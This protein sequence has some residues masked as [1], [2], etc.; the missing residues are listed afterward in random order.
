MSLTS[1]N[2]SKKRAAAVAAVALSSAL[3]LS[4]CSD[5]GEDKNGAS[6]S[7]EATQSAGSDGADGSTKAADDK[8]L[9]FKDSYVTAKPADKNMTSVFGTLHNTTDK[10]ITITEVKGDIDGAKYELH[11]VNRDGEMQQIS[12]LTI[13]AGEDSVLEPGGNHIMI[14]EVSDEIAA[15]DSLAFTLVDKDGK[16]YKLDNVPVRVQQSTH[17]HYG[18]AKDGEMGN[19]D[20]MQHGGDHMQHGGEHGHEH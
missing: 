9:E 6:T 16:E 11:E 7:A 17:E 18:D 19:M 13:P 3:F 1:L 5:D 15:G 10:D 20:G 2:N 8:A 12:S 4:A 14:M